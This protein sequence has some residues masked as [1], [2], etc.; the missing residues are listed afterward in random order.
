M[1]QRLTTQQLR[2]LLRPETALL[3]LMLVGVVTW[4]VLNQQAGDAQEEEAVVQRQVTAAGDDLSFWQ[5]T[6]GASDLQEEI[7]RLVARGLSNPEI[8]D[9]LMVSENTVKSHIKNI[10]GKLH[11][12]NRSEAAT[13]A[14]R[15][16]LTKPG[17]R[18]S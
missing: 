15:M 9:E 4:Y 6:Y 16:G 14:A 13:Y 2:S 18:A 11:M 1:N 12:K 17:S 5:A 8:A 7:L 10:L 3:G